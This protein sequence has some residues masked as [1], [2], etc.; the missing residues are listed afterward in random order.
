VHNELLKPRSGQIRSL[1]SAHFR[2]L[3]YIRN[4]RGDALY[5]IAAHQQI[6]LDEIKNA[7]AGVNLPNL[8]GNRQYLANDSRLEI[9]ARQLNQLMTERGLLSQADDLRNL[10]SNDYLPDE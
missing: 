10:I 1:V 4:N 6:T 9:A 3:E 8:S 2:G 5:R 7:L